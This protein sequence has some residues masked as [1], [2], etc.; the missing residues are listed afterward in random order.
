M[1]TRKIV[2]YRTEFWEYCNRTVGQARCRARKAGVPFGITRLFVDQLFVDQDWRCAV[3]GIPFNPPIKLDGGKWRRDPLAPSL[4]R[5]VP[6]AGYVEGN[7]RL[8]NNVINSAMQ[9]WGLETLLTVF[10]AMAVARREPSQNR[11]EKRRAPNKAIPKP[12]QRLIHFGS[13]GIKP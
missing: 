3:S 10:S 7:V 6:A 13:L 4:D 5:I 2:P 1:K 9:E 11:S 12:F 8:V